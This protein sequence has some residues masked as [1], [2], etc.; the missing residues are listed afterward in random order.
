ME[1]KNNGIIITQEENAILQAKLDNVESV[2][3]WLSIVH[4]LWALNNL[5][6]TLEWYP[7]FRETTEYRTKHM[8]W[9]NNVR[10]NTKDLSG[11]KRSE[12]YSL[13]VMVKGTT[14]CFD[15]GEVLRYRIGSGG[16]GSNFQ[17]D[18]LSLDVDAFPKLKDKFQNYYDDFVKD[19]LKEK[20]QIEYDTMLKEL[21]TEFFTK[22]DAQVLKDKKVLQV[23][24]RIKTIQALLRDAEKYRLACIDEVTDKAKQK[25]KF[26]IPKSES[27]FINLSVMHKAKMAQRLSNGDYIANEVI[28]SDIDAR[29]QEILDANAELF[30]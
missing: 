17:Y 22:V 14:G 9:T 30:I 24:S 21:T 29:F 10:G 19:G 27:P 6:L 13:T 16:G 1:V 7:D 3:D 12:V 20:M 8:S 18:H 4:E 26:D 15:G 23:N 28:A 5:S 25:H 11:K 2:S